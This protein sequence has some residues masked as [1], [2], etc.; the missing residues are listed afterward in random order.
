MAGDLPVALGRDSGGGRGGQEIGPRSDEAY[1]GGR[2]ER[3]GRAVVARRDR[4]PA[5]HARRLRAT[6]DAYAVRLEAEPL[7]VNRSDWKEKA[8]PA[9][10]R[11]PF[12]ACRGTCIDGRVQSASSCVRMDHEHLYEFET[13]IQVLTEWIISSVY[14]CSMRRVW[15]LRSVS[16][17]DLLYCHMKAKPGSI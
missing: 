14:F 8:C 15:I 16:I 17:C 6:D 10:V 12:A 7:V 9:L 5:P 3:P 2:Q 11:S 13:G 1:D 4:N